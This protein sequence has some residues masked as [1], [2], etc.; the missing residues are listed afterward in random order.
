[1]LAGPS[2]DLVAAVRAEA[3]AGVADARSTAVAGYAHLGAVDLSAGFEA[4]ELGGDHRPRS[5]GLGPDVEGFHREIVDFE[6]KLPHGRF[7]EE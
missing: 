4:V 5:G 6:C 1:G 7:S 2:A 3:V